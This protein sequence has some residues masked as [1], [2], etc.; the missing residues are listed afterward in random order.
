MSGRIPIG[1]A[2]SGI[3]IDPIEEGWTPIDVV[4]VARCMMPDGKM[5][6][7]YIYTEG[8]DDILAAGM[9]RYIAIRLDRGFW[10]GGDEE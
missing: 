4:V 8:V 10:Q 9:V 2:L 1:E 7:Q 3:D 5:G 6:Y